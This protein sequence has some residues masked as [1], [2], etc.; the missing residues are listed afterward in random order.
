M[1]YSWSAGLLKGASVNVGT[2]YLGSR[3]GDTQEGITTLGVPIQPSFY[4]P[5]R[6]LLNFGAAIQL[7]RYK[8]RLN[9][10]NALDEQYIFGSSR[11][12]TYP[13]TPFNISLRVTTRF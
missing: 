12:I 7:A 13:G 6:T 4:L 11:L 3:P 8:L 5:P 9:V 2:S 1:S 10:D